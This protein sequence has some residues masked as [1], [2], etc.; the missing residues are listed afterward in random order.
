[1]DPREMETDVRHVDI[2]L[3]INRQIHTVHDE[4]KRQHTRLK[5]RKPSCMATH[6]LIPSTGNTKNRQVYRDRED[7]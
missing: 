7:Y 3:A 4:P 2:C 6:C 5:K 1:M